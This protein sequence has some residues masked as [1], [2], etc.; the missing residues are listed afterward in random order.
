MREMP[1]RS[2]QVLD[3]AVPPASLRRGGS[4]ALLAMAEDA[5]GCQ[6][7]LHRI[8]P[9]R[10]WLERHAGPGAGCRSVPGRQHTARARA[11]QRDDHRAVPNLIDLR[12]ASVVLRARLFC[13]DRRVDL[14]LVCSAVVPACCLV[15]GPMWR[16]PFLFK[17]LTA[18]TKKPALTTS[19]AVEDCVKACLKDSQHRPKREIT[20]SRASSNAVI[21]ITTR[22]PLLHMP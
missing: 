14:D 9:G 13:A 4:R 15:A 10:P 18:N 7:C 3:V 8:P 21:L 2:T 12:A 11:R 16:Y 6:V 1:K 20:S 19:K 5:P 22:L 17:Y